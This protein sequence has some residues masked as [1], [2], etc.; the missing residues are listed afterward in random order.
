LIIALAAAEPAATSGPVADYQA[1]TAQVKRDAEQAVGRANEWL[2]KG[3]GILARQ[4]LGLAYAELGRWAPSATAFETAAREAENAQDPNRADFWVQAGNGWLAAGDAAKALKAFDAALATT[5]L[6]GGL[7]GE[8]HLDRAR[9]EVAL[10]DTA[11]ARR[12][13]DKAVE[14]VPNDPMAWYL[15]SALALKQKDLKRAQGDIAEALKRAPED[16]DLL[17]QA[18]NVAGVSGETEAA[19][20]LFQKA[21]AVAPN[22]DAAKAARAALAADK[23]PFPPAGG[24]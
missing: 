9:A 18:G 5:S 2:V 23:P 3:G 1:C 7:R 15:S 22:S 11:G 14:L 24:D 6:A 21:I 16:A 12:D 8:V 13:L 17:V 10:G 20:G 4:C 19:K